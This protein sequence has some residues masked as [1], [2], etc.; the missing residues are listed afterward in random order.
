MFDAL[1]F[2]QT[3]LNIPPRWPTLFTAEF[4]YNSVGNKLQ[5]H[6]GIRPEKL[7]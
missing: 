3:F 6:A 1:L 7:K 4:L 2:D 5:L